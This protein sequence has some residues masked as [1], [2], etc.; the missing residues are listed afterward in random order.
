VRGL[1]RGLAA[2]PEQ[3]SSPTFVLLTSYPGA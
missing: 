1:A 2:D 3:V